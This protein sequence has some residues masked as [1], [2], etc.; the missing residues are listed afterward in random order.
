M[1]GKCNRGGVSTV[2]NRYSKANNKYMYDYDSSQPS[3]YIMSLDVVNLYGY[4]MSFK[5]QCGN[6]RFIDETDKFDFQKV[7]LNGEK[8]YLLEVD[9]NYPPELHDAHSDLPL[10]PEHITV[11]P[12]MLSEYNS[13]DQSFRG[14]TCLVPNLRDKSRYVLHIRNLKL[15]TDLSMKVDQIHK[16]LEFDQK[17]ILAPDI[18]FNTDKRSMARSSFEKDFSN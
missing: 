12:Q 1:F 18:A 14:Q 6:F 9:L 5:L 3:S 7:D 15:Y 11:T 17:A 2:S 8:G 10:A 4:Y 13:G 16:V